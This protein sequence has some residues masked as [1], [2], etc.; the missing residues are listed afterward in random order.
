MIDNQDKF[1][2]GMLSGVVFYSIMLWMSSCTNFA[3]VS[4][5][6]NV[7][8][9][10]IGNVYYRTHKDSIEIKRDVALAEAKMLVEVSKSGGEVSAEVLKDAVKNSLHGYT[11]AAPK[12]WI[13]PNS[14]KKNN[15]DG[16][17]KEVKRVPG[18]PDKGKAVEHGRKDSGASDSGLG[19]LPV[20]KPIG[21]KK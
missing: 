14:E 18:T 9:E 6:D 20:L 19:S 13:F 10:N 8:V 11:P 15:P 16:G 7:K 4:N 17:E 5:Q 3:N 21:G 2:Y 1:L 12:G